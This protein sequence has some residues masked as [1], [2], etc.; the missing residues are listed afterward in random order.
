MEFGKNNTP[1]GEAEFAARIA[2]TKTRMAGLGLDALIC[3]D[4]ANMNYLTGYDGWSFYVHQC[5]IVLQDLEHP[6]WFGRAQDVNGAKLTTILPAGNILGY[7]DD[8]VQSKVKHP[9]Q[10]VAR[11]LR[12]RGRARAR[13]GVETDSYYFTGRSLDTLRAELPDARILDGDGLVNWVRVVKSDS[14]IA[15]M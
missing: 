11:L 13:I 4:P 8:F 5:V 2:A 3:S 7:A 9:M 14:E 12:E 6:L 1:F 15:M 10:E